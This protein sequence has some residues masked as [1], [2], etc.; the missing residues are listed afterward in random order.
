MFLKMTNQIQKKQK[1]N[2]WSGQGKVYWIFSRCIRVSQ[3]V[4]VKLN[5]L[6]VVNLRNSVILMGNKAIIWLEL[7][8]GTSNNKLVSNNGV[9][10]NG[11]FTQLHGQ[12]WHKKNKLVKFDIQKTKKT[13]LYPKYTTSLSD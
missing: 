2:L 11:N 7:R 10:S 12:Y 3:I 5:N 4:D 1:K 13:I 8:L 9:G 6:T